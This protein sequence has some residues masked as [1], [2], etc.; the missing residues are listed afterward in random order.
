[1]SRRINLPVTY[2]KPH[3]K[4]P[5]EAALDA[6]LYREMQKAGGKPYAPKARSKYARP[7]C[8]EDEPCFRASGRNNANR[9]RYGKVL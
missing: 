7:G 1:M 3:K 8:Q 5:K 6:H 4:T 9:L 2:G